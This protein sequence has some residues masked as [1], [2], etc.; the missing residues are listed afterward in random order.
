[1][2]SVSVIV[3]VK[4]SESTIGGT[5]ESLL[6]QSYRG[7]LEIVLVGDRG[8]TTWTALESEIAAGLVRVLEVEVETGGRDS[9][10][11]RNVGLEA[12]TGEVLCLTDSDMVLPEEWVATGVDLIAAGRHC[13][14]G[15]MESVDRKFW[16]RYVDDNS[17]ASKTPRMARP[18]CLDRATF[19]VGAR[20]P[21]ITANVLFS[22][23]L[24]ERVGGLDPE[25]VHSY[26]DYEWFQ[27]V[28]DAGFEILC[29]PRL[30]AQHH[31]RQGWSDLVREYRGSGRGCAQ[32][33]RKH[34]TSPLSRRRLLQL[35]LVSA[36]ACVMTL[37]VAAPVM[38]VTVADSLGPL[39]EGAAATGVVL[40]FG[41][42]L[43]RTRRLSAVV[44]PLVTLVLGTA[45]S[46]G[47]VLGLM[48]SARLPARAPRSVLGAQRELAE[49]GGA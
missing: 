21:P 24:Y 33:V 43:L 9:N 15:P 40:V 38:G 44:F 11:K 20:K 34:P 41:V 3:P 8:D 27:R 32:F 36:A 6:R 17:L 10:F 5:V 18:Y 23:V 2:N 28:V 37:W 45:F 7:P 35:A 42:S 46:F 14:A 12:A 26:E 39:G 16:G 48:A 19:A 29:T 13:V 30:S 1:M 47:M 49:R 31:H 4:G 25:F 22:R